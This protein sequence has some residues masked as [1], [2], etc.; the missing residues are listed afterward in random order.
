MFSHLLFLFYVAVLIFGVSVLALLAPRYFQTKAHRLGA[1]LLL[2]INITGLLVSMIIQRYIEI[3]LSGAGQMLSNLLWAL[4]KVTYP[5]LL[6]TVPNY[7]LAL[8][9]RSWRSLWRALSLWGAIG[10]VLVRIFPFGLLLEGQRAQL[11]DKWIF[12][13]LSG[14]FLLILFFVLLNLSKSVFFEGKHQNGREIGFNAGL[15]AF[16]FLGFV[17]DMYNQYFPIIFERSG[18]SLYLPFFYFIW[19]LGS[20]IFLFKGPLSTVQMGSDNRA[21]FDRFRITKREK[22]IIALLEH[23]K[24]NRDIADA[25]FISETT[26]KRH[27][28]NIFQKASVSSRFELIQSLKSS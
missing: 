22:E 24:S 5:F 9:G 2:F 14:L 8:S 15:V 13:V 7:Y 12:F 27:L 20:A 6:F 21:F 25:L 16:F 26:V 3:N 23:G 18:Q 10:F 4:N 17:S 1:F 11:V 28:Q 19:V